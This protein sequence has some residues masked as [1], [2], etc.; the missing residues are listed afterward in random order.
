MMDRVKAIAP[1]SIDSMLDDAWSDVNQVITAVRS[2]SG[3]GAV[4]S[5]VTTAIGAEAYEITGNDKVN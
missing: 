4:R 5:A 1:G 2:D 3:L